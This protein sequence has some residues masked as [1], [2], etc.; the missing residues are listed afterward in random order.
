MSKSLGNVIEPMEVMS[1]VTLEA[2]TRGWRRATYIRGKGSSQKQSE[3]INLDISRVVGYRR[4]CD[5][6]RSA[7]RFARSKLGG[8]Y[9]PP[10]I[11]ALETMPFGCEWILSL[12][13]RAI[14]KT[15]ASLNSYE[16]SD[17]TKAVY[18]WWQQLSEVII[19]AIKPYYVGDDI[20]VPERTAAQFV[21]W[22]CLDYGLR[23]LHPFMP[24][25]SEELWHRF[26]SLEG[27]ER[28]ESIMTSDYP[29]PV[30]VTFG[31][32]E[33]LAIKSSSYSYYNNTLQVQ[34]EVVN[35]NSFQF[36]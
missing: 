1:G 9:I 8:E 4:W 6:A 34:I 31:L 15:V 18:S 22:L 14:V 23:M 32:T 20:F 19:V 7:V 17:A 10:E 28:N 27:V 13:N 33:T 21:L 12:L 25:V 11:L 26:P 3:K 24:F 30:E 36:D 35:M 29:S 16:F 5:K 2:F